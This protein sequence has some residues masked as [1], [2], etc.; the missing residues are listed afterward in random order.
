MDFRQLQTFLTVKDL[1]SFTKAAER[2]GY[3]QSSIT[4]QIQQLESELDVR[5]FERLGKAIT[6]TDAGERLV[7]YAAQLLQLA[8]TMKSAVAGGDQPS[9]TLT[10]GTAESLSVTRLP[11]IL[12]AYRRLYPE[13]ELR[14]KLLGCADVLPNL[15]GNEVDLAFTIGRRLESDAVAQLCALP[16]EICILAAKNHPLAGML[17]VTAVDFES[18]PLL[19]TGDGC[20]YRA[21]FLER[22]DAAGIAPM[23][24]LETDS[25]QVIKQAAVSGLGVCVLPATAVAGEV[26]DG[27]LVPLAFDTGG[28]D[29]VSQL[30]IHKDKWLSPAL[31][32]F[33]G[34]AKEM[35]G[36]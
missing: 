18:M 30:V 14:L 24:A 33:I 7:P 32:A 8:K 26:A 2:L 28:F 1:L 15:S 34:L 3:A 20:S 21:A 29:I 31:N 16:E 13:V 23:L 19:L 12:G 35:L 5:L 36:K 10:V 22:L 27:R 17:R 11:A 9:G 6:L 4:A 25:I